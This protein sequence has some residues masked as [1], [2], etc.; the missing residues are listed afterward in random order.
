VSLSAQI[1]GASGRILILKFCYCRPGFSKIAFITPILH[2]L[3]GLGTPRLR[4]FLVS[5]I[6]WTAVQQL[7]SSLDVTYATAWKIYNTKSSNLK[8]EHTGD[9]SMS[10]DVLSLIGKSC[11]IAC[12]CLIT[13]NYGV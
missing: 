5:L 3:M 6:P 8:G 11:I 12:E 13:N 7:K 9:M 1:L 2:I 4:R 10:N